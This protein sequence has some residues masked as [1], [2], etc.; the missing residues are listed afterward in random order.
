M[1]KSVKLI[2]FATLCLMLLADV[3]FIIVATQFNVMIVVP[4]ILSAAYL[5]FWA[6]SAT[7]AGAK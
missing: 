2:V 3:A 7:T 5:V 4:A 6:A 1:P